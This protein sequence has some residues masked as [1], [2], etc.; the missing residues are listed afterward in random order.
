MS[1]PRSPEQANAILANKI[2]FLN[3]KKINNQKKNGEELSI[4]IS[5][6][7]LGKRGQ[8]MGAPFTR[9][10]IQRWGSERVNPIIQC[11]PSAT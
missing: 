11:P 8:F 2:S 1:F 4:N 7:G 10:I 6:L 3:K 5:I 9:V